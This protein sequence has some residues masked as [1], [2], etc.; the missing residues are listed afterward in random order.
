MFQPLYN[1]QK[2]LGTGGQ[3]VC[4]AARKPLIKYCQYDRILWL[5]SKNTHKERETNVHNKKQSVIV[6]VVTATRSNVVCGNNCQ[7][8]PTTIYYA[9]CVC[10]SIFPHN[11]LC[12]I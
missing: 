7:R 5:S 11:Y 4:S 6:F 2:L 3:L 8:I 12:S 1:H 9:A 10:E